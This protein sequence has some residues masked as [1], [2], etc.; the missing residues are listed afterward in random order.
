VLF[1][2]DAQW[3]DDATVRTL[4]ALLRRGLTCPWIV[5]L[6]MRPGE[7]ALGMQ[8]LLSYASR[9][10]QLM[11]VELAPLNDTESI[12]LARQYQLHAPPH[13]ITKA[14]GNPFMLVELLRY[15][16]QRDERL[17]A[18]VRDLIATRIQALTP[19]A[20]RFIDAAA[21]G[22]RDFVIAES[23][24]LAELSASETTDAL[25]E[26]SRHGLVRLIDAHRGRFDHPLTVESILALIG[27]ARTHQLN[28]TMALQL[29]QQASPPHAQIVRHYQAAGDCAA[30][31]PHA[32]AAARHAMQ[33]GAWSE[34]EYYLRLVIDASPPEHHAAYWLE[35]GE[36]LVM[37]GSFADASAALQHAIVN[38]ESPDGRTADL[39]RLALA[40]S[41]I[42]QARYDEAIMLC[43]P[44]L[45]HPQQSITMHAA[46]VCG[47]AHSLL[48]VDLAMARTY[49]ERAERV[50]H[51]VEDNDILPRIYFEHGGILAQQG[52]IPAAIARYHAALAAAIVATTHASR[53]WQIFAHNNLAYHIHLLGNFD[54]ATRH[55][56]IGLRLAQRSG[57]Y[58]VQSYLHSTMGEI[59]LAQGDL[60]GAERHFYEGLDIAERY[61][62][63]ERIAGIEANIGLVARARED[64]SSATRLLASAMNK[65]D[66][67]GVHHLAAQIR[68]WLASLL[69]NEEAQ[70]R[71]AEATVLANN[72]E[73][74]R[75]IAQIEAIRHLRNLTGEISKEH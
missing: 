68:I 66:A 69:T 61:G 31:A 54:E 19:N 29:S 42:P 10:R 4:L 51:S 1:F 44:L 63:L 48:G 75:L 73:R 72:G 13:L 71:L 6:T 64:V 58:M 32:L 70:Q 12:E 8:R 22:G 59:A 36:I 41:Y 24:T 47:T 65:A 57:V 15:H 38:D 39:A 52:D 74:Q 34:A 26:L 53:I 49:L 35:L 17:P 18:A 33:L 20:R 9:Q 27:P 46:F 11:H 40:R 67:L 3:L 62:M 23:A 28:R 50:S 2:D 25:D 21:I 37:S 55:A 16:D 56:R 14:E 60:D 43:E 45:E 30:A 7:Q 5:L